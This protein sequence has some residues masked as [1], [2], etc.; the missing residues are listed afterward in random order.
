VIAHSI[1]L[2][3][4]LAIGLRSAVVRKLAVPVLTTTLLTTTLTGPAADFSLAGGRTARRVLS[5]VAMFAWAL[6]GAILLR[7]LSD[8][9][10]GVAA[11]IVAGLTFNLYLH[12]R[13]NLL[14]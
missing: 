4:A 3:T 12:A 5:I 6:A 9:T 7:V 10:A 14:R 11:L 8:S 2:S 13:K 1:V